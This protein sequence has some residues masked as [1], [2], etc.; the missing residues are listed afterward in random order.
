MDIV[1]F[2]NASQF[3]GMCGRLLHAKYETKERLDYLE[4]LAKNL[5][6]FRDLILSDKY[7]IK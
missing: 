2:L 1:A 5:N 6:C 3:Q 7:K 4:R